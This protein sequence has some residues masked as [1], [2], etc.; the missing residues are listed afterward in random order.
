MS[1]KEES[2][3]QMMALANRLNN[4]VVT[5]QVRKAQVIARG[6]TSPKRETKK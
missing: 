6:D 1:K 3:V 2:V 4:L 5:M